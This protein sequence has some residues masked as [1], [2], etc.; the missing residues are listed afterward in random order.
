MKVSA[1]VEM[2]L[3]AN[4]TGLL[5]KLLRKGELDNEQLVVSWRSAINDAHQG[6]CDPEE[7]VSVKT[8]VLL[9]ITHAVKNP[10]GWIEV[11]KHLSELQKLLLDSLSS[12]EGKISS[13]ERLSLFKDLN[14]LIIIIRSCA[15][16]R[17]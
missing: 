1:L 15:Q 14:N 8:E 10:S 16:R 3:F 12:N 9:A 2:A 4:R 11:S 17:S 5:D 13:S 6:V 7:D